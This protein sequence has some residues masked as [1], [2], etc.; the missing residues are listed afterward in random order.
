MFVK[1]YVRKLCRYVSYFQSPL[2]VF[3][4]CL[5]TL[6]SHFGSTTDEIII[7]I[8]L[9]Y[10]TGGCFTKDVMRMEKYGELNT[11]MQLNKLNVCCVI[12]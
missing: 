4:N 7:C 10:P 3:F 6:P 5:F 8:T 11:L 2:S 12:S 9:I 1:C